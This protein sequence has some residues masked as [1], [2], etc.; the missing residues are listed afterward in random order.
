M[1]VKGR[2]ARNK[3]TS[4]NIGCR[5]RVPHMIFEV[6]VAT[7]RETFLTNVPVS[8]VRRFPEFRHVLSEKRLPQ[9]RLVMSHPEHRQANLRPSA[10]LTSNVDFTSLVLS[11]VLKLISLAVTAGDLDRV[12]GSVAALNRSSRKLFQDA[13]SPQKPR[14]SP[15]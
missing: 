10:T 7:A 3:W 11:G 2:T 8:T 1:R 12:W 15:S 4:G 6:L 14:S 13:V 5:E 9:T